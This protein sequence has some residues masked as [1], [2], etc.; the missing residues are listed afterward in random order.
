MRKTNKEAKIEEFL[1]RGVEEVLPSKAG[2]KKL[3]LQK[4][5]RVY[6]G[7]DPTSP[8][9]HL[10]HVIPLRKLQQLVEMGHEVILLFGT[11]T[12]RIGDP[13]GKDKTR[14]PLSLEEIKKNMRTYRKQAGKVLDLSK[15]KI[16]KNGEWLDKM[17][18][19]KFFKLASHM[20]VARLLERD[21]FQ[22]RI[23]EKKEIYIHEFLYPL[24]QGY[25]SVAMNVDLE[26]GGSDQ[27]FNML[28]GRK[29]QLIY[30][31]K[32]KY[33]LTVKLIEGLDGRKMSKTF[34][35]TVNLLDPPQEMFGKLMSMK[36]E[37]IIPYFE[38][39]SGVDWEE[40]K[41]IKR[42]LQKGLLS[43][44]EAKEILA[45][46]IVKE[47]WGVKKAK[48]A[49][50]EFNRVF[51]RKELPSKIPEVLIEP[52]EMPLADLIFKVGLVSSKSEAKRVIVQGGV[53]VD[54]EVIKDWKYIINPTTGMIVQVGKRRFVRLKTLPS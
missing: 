5:I 26:I 48:R 42:S 10:G 16:M 21:M 41:R 2:L 13:T 27:L 25:D 6:L 50:E 32:E 9:L 3:L 46:E 31:K 29:L 1:K 17:R 12:A 43:P 4:R 36:D 49:R 37:L 40:V 53:K 14:T 47:F 34:G 7:V 35:N 22:R 18:L 28:V 52:Q 20:T 11:F 44:R 54:K 24:L 30:N 19:D 8:H 39:V 15:V 33:V 38:L 45:F 51:S 23:Q